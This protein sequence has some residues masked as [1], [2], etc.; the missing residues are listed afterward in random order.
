M[1]WAVQTNLWYSEDYVKRAKN[2]LAGQFPITAF[3]GS[4]LPE[5]SAFL[6][7]SLKSEINQSADR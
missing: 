5:P 1:Q 3:I 4:Y 6:R 7:L 2:S